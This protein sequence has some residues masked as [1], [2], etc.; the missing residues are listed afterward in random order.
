[1]ARIR[2]GGFAIQGK[3]RRKDLGR[4]IV[5][6]FLMMGPAVR[7]ADFTVAKGEPAP[8]ITVTIYNYAQVPEATLDKAEAVAARIFERAGI[9]NSWQELRVTAAGVG[10]IPRTF[11]YRNEVNIVIH[12]VPQAMAGRLS[13]SQICLGLAVVA[14]GNKGGDVAYVFYQR[15]EEMV[16]GHDLTAADSLGHAMAHEI[17]H[18]LLGERSHS[19]IGLMRARW[20]KSDLQSAAAGWLIFT[21]AE[22][23]RLRAQVRERL[24]AK[25][26]ATASEI[27]ASK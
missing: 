18:L 4:A 11:R 9:E 25:I 26:A 19:P 24:A 8:K 14:E 21:D 6:G 15:V 27:A 5:C 20:N 22:A 10:T 23:V 7:S 13:P 12:I 3:K 2:D 17:G 16:R 1:M